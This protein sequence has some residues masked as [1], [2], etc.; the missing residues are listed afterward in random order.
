[1]AYPGEGLHK[2]WTDYKIE[3][4]SNGRK[5]LSKEEWLKKRKQANSGDA[6][7]TTAMSDY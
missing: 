2:E 5:A 1:M 6:P 4:E 3:E 7:K